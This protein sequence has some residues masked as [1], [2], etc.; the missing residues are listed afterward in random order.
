MILKL[1]PWT[2]SKLKRILI[3]KYNQCDDKCKFENDLHWHVETVH[4][5]YIEIEPNVC[6]DQEENDNMEWW[7]IYEVCELD[8]EVMTMK[9]WKKL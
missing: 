3:R 7:F 1:W 8:E 4:K 9:T 5:S 2:R 6:S